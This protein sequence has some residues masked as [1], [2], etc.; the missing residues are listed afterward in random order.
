MKWFKFY[1]QDFLT[2]TKL[3]GL[4]PYQRLMWVT[5]LC[6]A[7]QDET[8]SGV[9]KYFDEKRL[10]ELSGLNYDDMESMYGTKP[11]VTIVTFCNMGLVTRL[12]TETLLVTNYHKKQTQQSTSA[13]RVA[14]WRANKTG[15]KQTKVGVTDVTNVTLQRNGRVDKSRRD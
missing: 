5:L 15:K 3:S 14:S 9:L 7:S 13:E 12:D 11:G 8:K 10:V 1:G 6:I 2:D 4:N